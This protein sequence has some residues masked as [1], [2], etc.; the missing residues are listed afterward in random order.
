MGKSRYWQLLEAIQDW[1]SDYKGDDID[2]INPNW[3][4]FAAILYMGKIYE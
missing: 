4:E 1:F 2:F 3:K